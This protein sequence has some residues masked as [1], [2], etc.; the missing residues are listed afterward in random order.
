M[1]NIFK[2]NMLELQ[3]VLPLPVL[4]Y[5]CS[6]GAIHLVLCLFLSL[7][8]VMANGVCPA[9]QFPEGMVLCFDA[10]RAGEAVGIDLGDTCCCCRHSKAFV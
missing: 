1:E 9:L 6:N 3:K 10:H 2:R 4:S 7:A 8:E 5:L